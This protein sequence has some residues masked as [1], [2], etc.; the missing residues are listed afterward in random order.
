MRLIFTAIVFMLFC[1]ENIFAGTNGFVD[2]GSH[3]ADFSL[4]VKG[5]SCSILDVL[6]GKKTVLI[7]FS[8]DCDHC[9][10]VLDAL[11]CNKTRVADVAPAYADAQIVLVNLYEKKSTREYR[12]LHIP[13]TWIVGHDRKQILMFS[14][15]YDLKNYPCIY[16][17]NEQGVIEGKDIKIGN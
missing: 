16:L 10:S 8:V 12:K 17:I 14:K 11:S 15:D 6:G 3:V 9:I 7:F 13:S 4:K 1:S 5:K 2:V